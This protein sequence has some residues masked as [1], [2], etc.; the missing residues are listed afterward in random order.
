MDNCKKLLKEMEQASTLY[1]PGVFWQEASKLMFESLNNHGFDS[2][3]RLPWS[4]IF[5]V[6]TYGSPGSSLSGKHIESLQEWIVQ[7]NL[8][9]KQTQLLSTFSSG[10]ER[11]LADYR[12]LVAS[13]YQTSLMPRL[14]D[15]SESTIGEPKEQFE[16]DGKRYSRSALN[17][18]LGL[19][20]FKK[21]AD[22]DNIGIIMEIGG[23]FGT[24]G[25]IVYKLMPT[26]RYINIDIPPTLC[27]S[28]YYLQQLVGRTEIKHPLEFLSF[29][30]IQIEDLNLINV[31]ASWQVEKLK[32]K[33]DLFVN[34]IS[35]QEME[36]EIVEN[37]LF[38]VSRLQAEWVLLRNMREGKP[39]KAQRRFG[40]DKPIYSEDYARMLEGYEL[41]D[42]NVIPFGFKTV[43]GFHSELM[44]F[45]RAV[46]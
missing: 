41:V 11:A 5:F 6:P 38:H 17:Y 43:D 31:F 8:N 14:V 32:G 2:F 42:T 18:L 1:Q 9:S 12:T 13:E 30:S 44:L 27:C 21:H 10:E 23:G 40:V 39:L 22:L 34:F 46:Y 25:E 20:F 33:I 28:T 15:F 19:S 7:Q 37:Y 35:F 3:R 36:P 29:T 24:M 26:T 16:F 45:K 4:L